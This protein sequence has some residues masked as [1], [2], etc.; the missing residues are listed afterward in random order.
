M[1]KLKAAGRWIAK[2]ILPWL[3]LLVAATTDGIGEHVLNLPTWAGS[4]LLSG[5]GMLGIAGISPFP[6]TPGLARFFGY[7][8]AG[9]AAALAGHAA[10]QVWPPPDAHVV[11]FH[12]MGVA[13]AIL[14]VI[15]GRQGARAVLG[16]PPID[17]TST[18]TPLD[19]PPPPPK[20]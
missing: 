3:A 7:L 15:G 18:V 16:R 6:V 19:R 14:G 13:G 10:G 11:L 2:N 1:E 8:S 12:I 17:T 4:L 20:T 5:A 9:A